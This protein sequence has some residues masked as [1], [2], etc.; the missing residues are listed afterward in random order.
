M[1][2]I[3]WL[4]ASVRDKLERG[5]GKTS[6]NISKLVKKKKRRKASFSIISLVPIYLSDICCIFSKSTGYLIFNC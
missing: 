3:E 2:K 4:H 5:V 1:H 6:G